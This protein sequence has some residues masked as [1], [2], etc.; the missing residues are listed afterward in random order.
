MRGLARMMRRAAD[1]PPSLPASLPEG[2]RRNTAPASDGVPALPPGERRNTA[3]AREG[4]ASLSPRERDRGRGPGAESPLLAR[5]RQLRTSQTEAELRLWYHLRASRFLGLKF[6]RQMPLGPYI[7]D[8]V[9]VERRL[10]IELDGGQHA[11][12]AAYDARRD[13][14]MRQQGFTVMRFWNNA[15]LGETEAVLERIR[16]LVLSRP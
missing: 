1:E 11:E 2:E 13:A 5:A 3:S 10:V 12:Q 6:R 16:E 7:A 14:W 8:F 15:V 9:C 4:L